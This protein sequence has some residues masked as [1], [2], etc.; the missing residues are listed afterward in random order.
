MPL[1]FPLNPSNGDIYDNY[2]YSS[3]KGAWLL[4][5]TSGIPSEINDLQD[6]VTTLDGRVTTAETTVGTFNTRVTTAENDINALELQVIA[7][8]NLNGNTISANYSIPAGYNGVSAGPITIANGVTVTIPDGSAW[9][10]V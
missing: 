1:N 4:N 9:S 6:A 3:T 8:I 5:D 2:T 7:P 10:I